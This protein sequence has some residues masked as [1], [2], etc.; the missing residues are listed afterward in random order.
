[1]TVSKT[2]RALQKGLAVKRYFTK[3]NVH[4]YEEV[5][6]DIRDALIPNFKEGGFA[7]EQRNV[8]FPVDWSVNATNIVAQKYF[9][10]PM[11]SPQREHSVK[12]L[13]DRVAD[14]ITGWGAKDGY[15]ATE[16]DR[17]TFSAELKHLLV[18]QKVS[19]NSPV[20]FNVGTEEKPQCSACQPWDALVSTPAG[21][22]PIGKIV[23]EN[24]VGLEVFDSSGSTRVVATKNN[25]V[26]KVF[27][28]LLRNGA[29]VEATGDHVVR[30]VADRR[31]T[32]EW[33]RVD[34]LT[35]GMR[36]HLHAHRSATKTATSSE[37]EVSEAALAG[38]LQAD[39][40][41]GQYTEGT[42]NSLTIEFI[43]AN[44]EEESWVKEHLDVVFPQV[45]R[46]IRPVE[47]L[48]EMARIRLYGE[49]LRP[50][51]ERYELLNRRHD[52]RVPEPL[53]TAGD[54]AVAAYLKSVFQSDG[55]CTVQGGSARV[56]MGVISERWTEDVQLLL[57]RVG[58]YSRRARK[59][60]SRPDRCDLW[61]VQIAY[62]NERES[63]AERIGFIGFD[64]ARRLTEG[65]SLDGKTVPD[66]R[67]EEIVEIA[68]LG[69]QTV[70]DI[71]TESGEYLS[72]NIVV[73][74]CFILAVDDTMSSILNWYV[75]EGTIFKGGSGSGINLSTIRSSKERLSA[76][77]EASGPVSFMRGADA[78]AG[79]IKSGG[80][81]RRAA[82]MVV[83]NVDHPDV[84][85]FIWC[86][87]HEEK[88]AR[89]LA[90]A[91]FE[92]DLNGKDAHSIQYQNAN[93]SVRVTDDFMHTYMNDA[94]WALRAVQ[95]GRPVDEIEARSLM[96]S[97]AQAAWECADPGMQYD[98]TIN[99][100]HT[101][102][103]SGRINASNPCFPGDARVHTDKGLVRFDALMERVLE[104]ETF[105]VY[106]HDAT[107]P[108]SPAETIV[109]SKPTQFMTT[110]VNEIVKLRFSDGRELRC[111]PNHRI[112][113]DNRGWVHAEEL[114]E[115]DRITTLHR[116]TAPVMADLHLPVSTD[117]ASYTQKGDWTREINIPEK[118]DDELAHYVGWL[119]GE[120]C[121]SGDV[122]TTSY[123]SD[124]DASEILPRH[125]AL[126]ARLNG[127]V[128]PKPTTL[129]NGT[130]QLRLSSR[131]L[132]RFFETLGVGTETV[133]EKHVPW[134]VFEAPEAIQ[135]AFLRGLF[136]ANGCAVD[137]DNGTRYVG[138][139]SSSAELLRGV[140][141]LLSSRA[142]RATIYDVT[143]KKP[144]TSEHAPDG[145]T[146]VDDSEDPSYEL[147]IAGRDREL[148]ASSVGF[149]LSRK[150]ERLAA[151]GAHA[152]YDVDRSVRLV[153]RE[154]AG[155]ELT[156]NLTE[157]RNHSYIVDGTVVSNC[158]EYMHLDN[159]ACNLAS[160]NLMKFV[161]E[162]LNFDIQAFRHAIDVVFLAQEI[163]VGNSSYP[164]ERI[165]QNAIDYRE[166][167]LGFA[168]LGA[169]LMSRGLPY[170]S[171]A[172]RA[173]AGA[174]SA[175]MTG[176][177]Y[178]VSAQVAESTGPYN[179]YAPNREAHL[180]VMRKHRAA[181]DDIDPELVP[182]GLLQ[183]AKGAW[184]EAIV[185]GEKHGY[186]NSQATV[187]APT[188]TIGLMMDCDT[189]G[190]EP[191][192]A[193]VKNKKLVGG[194]T[195]RI[196]NQT[197]PRALVRLGYNPAEVEAITNHIHE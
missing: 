66:I 174:I 86:K 110:G 172:G 195:M 115:D 146:V 13:I 144:R 103:A 165:G 37:L 128:E 36:M 196:V 64:K 61:E 44:V 140:S 182:E 49:A 75:E 20:W 57:F 142:I 7:F 1:M 170:D 171:E 134:S 90:E 139:G 62:R 181:V 124:D 5:E 105:E 8:Q 19:F 77:G 179:G 190:I 3:A 132:A 23:D 119:V 197:I 122:V 131:P 127:G 100:W 32:P 83:L 26:K 42:N 117:V 84:E 192:L 108:D 10:G 157:P 193:L 47:G 135:S 143:G 69:E 6:W 175:L 120:G 147:R 82:K 189:T 118:W 11:G 176:W 59:A 188:G 177:A 21:M 102:P 125:L 41:V 52:I 74:N 94:K 71:Q 46:K 194:G 91:G 14:T 55:F 68:D 54:E 129:A 99:D 152:S 56:A 80:K 17:E 38:W 116:A 153:S 39:G 107:N 109:L 133:A 185:L 112:W 92:M 78:S 141:V 154:F 53:W 33:K 178:R 96:R 97:M 150:Q 45:H 72:N 149:A 25:G 48:P 160:L 87:A 126:L 76:G 73:H 40:F 136:D 163:I 168:N 162:D 85:D 51:V 58:I 191:D 60:E 151:T 164:T 173:W 35:P 16:T 34:E 137:Q 89:A 123:G 2:E 166:L 63:F 88:K 70:Y 65:L 113:T 155:F 156:Y 30:A 27:R 22:V 18:H 145:E 43:T 67:E 187:I 138:L 93:N 15:F 161:D 184:E 167:G 169:L 101:C 29:F 111:T 9:R 114:N 79:T 12:Q 183:A 148:F 104:G 130:V 24:L 31:T 50:F 159:S 81:T 106:T 98:T 4:P 95:D 121:I 158:S 186:R 180:R 28:V